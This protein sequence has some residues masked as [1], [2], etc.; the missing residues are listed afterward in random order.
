MTLDLQRVFESQL[1]SFVKTC[2]VE[3]SPVYSTRRTLG[4]LAAL[5][6]HTE[7]RTSSVS[8]SESMASSLA[9]G[10]PQRRY[11]RRVLSKSNRTQTRSSSRDY[12]NWSDAEEQQSLV[13]EEDGRRSISVDASVSSEELLAPPSAP[14]RETRSMARK[15]TGREI[16]PSEK[17]GY[18]MTLRTRGTK[19]L[20][21]RESSSVS[22]SEVDENE[23]ED[24]SESDNVSLD[25]EQEE[26]DEE[27]EEEVAVPSRRT[28]RARLQSQGGSRTPRKRPRM[29]SDSDE[30][31]TYT[32]SFLIRSSRSG[33]LV[34]ANT[35]Y[36]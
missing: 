33:R 3:E 10:K 7:L 22:V 16:T 35:K 31:L 20:L 18:G 13:D 21:E 26:D 27:E 17:N 24:E 19:R 14:R 30:D 5:S 2:P 8:S 29:H 25:I 11:P 6:Q 34:K 9:S 36:S 28:R 23:Q 1:L 4:R 12:Q 15:K 32:P